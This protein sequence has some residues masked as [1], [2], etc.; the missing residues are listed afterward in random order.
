MGCKYSIPSGDVSALLALLP[1]LAAF[2]EEDHVQA[3]PIRQG[4]A[5]ALLSGAADGQPL[6]QRK[7][8]SLRAVEAHVES[9]VVGACIQDDELPCLLLGLQGYHFSLAAEFIVPMETENRPL[10]VVATIRC[11]HHAQRGSKTLASSPC[12][13]FEQAHLSHGT[14]HE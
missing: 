7:V 13:A 11:P 9:G 6:L 10:T 12:V 8:D 14:D 3:D 1:Q 2:A 5:V 4:R